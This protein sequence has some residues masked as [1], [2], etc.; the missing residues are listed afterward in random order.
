V[1]AIRNDGVKALESLIAEHKGSFPGAIRVLR[2]QK[3]DWFATA[4]GLHVGRGSTEDSDPVWRIEKDMRIT[5]ISGGRIHTQVLVTRYFD[6][7]GKKLAEKEIARSKQGMNLFL[8]LLAAGGLA[9]IF[10]V[11]RRR[12]ALTT[13]PHAA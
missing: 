8:I 12:A 9:G 5:S 13:T 11:L 6:R 3:T 10:Y 4:E 2:K 1:F 7:N